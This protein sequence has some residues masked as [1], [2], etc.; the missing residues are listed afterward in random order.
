M[1]RKELWSGRF[2]KQLDPAA[3]RFSSSPEDSSIL[4]FDIAGS[5]AHA[6]G[7]RR[8]GLIN[9]EALKC[10]VDGLRSIYASY[11]DSSSALLHGEED[12]HMAVESRLTEMYP[13]HGP[14]LHTGRSRNDQIALDLKMFARD[15]LLRLAEHLLQLEG[16]LL[17]VSRRHVNVPL[18]GYTHLQR[19]QPMYL[20]H[21]LLAHFW[22]FMRDIR[23][24]GALFDIINSS[25]LGAGAI[26]GTG[27]PLRPS[28]TAALLGFEHT[29]E[30]SLDATTDRDFALNIAYLSAL[31]SLH[32]SSLAE[33]MV[34]WNTSE[35]GF[36]SL[37]D[38]LSTG[39][40]LMPH[41]KN[42]DIAELVRGKSGGV[43]GELVSAMVTVKGLPLGYARDLQTVKSPLFHAVDETCSSLSMMSL[44]MDGAG[45]NRKKMLQSAS[46]ELTYSVEIVDSLVRNGMPFREAHSSLGKA[47]SASVEGGKKLEEV[48]SG[49]WPGMHFPSSP[50]EDIEMR[51]SAGGS[52]L[53]SVRRQ[54]DAAA[55]AVKSSRNWLSSCRRRVSKVDR[56]L[57]LK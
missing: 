30:N 45:F 41:K 43:I 11:A 3:K 54:L 53:S 16:V 5:I 34:L 12:I 56:L 55:D 23:L 18:P 2:R 42:P 51:S 57:G 33:E 52:S 21:H 44:L 26:G 4:K 14:R 24:A 35:F 27:L 31:I 13:A 37:P 19:A 9:D 39:S 15:G 50:S 6:N 17:K 46:D 38:S 22:R 49:L 28:Y 7:L 48:V 29:F 40:S 47:V 10:L 20:S 36:V 32:L 25:P 1:S 8:A